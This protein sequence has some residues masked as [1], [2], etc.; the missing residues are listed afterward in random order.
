MKRACSAV[1]PHVC[2]VVPAAFAQQGAGTE[3]QLLNR[4]VTEL[5]GRPQV[6]RPF[7]RR[8]KEAYGGR[9]HSFGGFRR[10][11]AR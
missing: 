9:N 5:Y 4:E 2:L 7:T 11:L 6:V 8:F 3:W 10:D 1:L